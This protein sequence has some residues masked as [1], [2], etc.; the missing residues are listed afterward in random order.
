MATIFTAL[1]TDAS[2]N[3]Y[4]AAMLQA[5]DCE[6][7]GRLGSEP[8]DCKEMKLLN[9]IVRVLDRGLA[10]EADPRHVEL[11]AKALGLETCRH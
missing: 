7:R 11:L 3:N 2:L 9:R 5:F 1:G 10:Y 6:L 4:E 8:Q